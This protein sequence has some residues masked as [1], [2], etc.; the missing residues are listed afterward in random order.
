VW[1]VLL[2]TLGFGLIGFVDDLLIITRGKNLGLRA[3][4]KLLGQFIVAIAF[5][6]WYYRADPT[7][8]AWDAPLF[9]APRLLLSVWYVFLMV[10]LSNA[11]NLT[12]GLDGLAAGV[13]LPSWVALGVIGAFS[14]V[15][16]GL[17]AATDYGLVV[18]CAAFA[19]AT[20]GYLWYN[21]HPAQV[22]MGD[23]GSL[24]IGGGLTA[25][26]IALHQ[27]WVLLV[28]TGIPLIEMFSVILQVLSFKLTKKRIFK[29]SPLHHHFELCELP[30]TRIVA[31]FGIASALFALT[32][33][34]IV[35]YR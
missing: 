35:F 9:T 34:L 30:E 26:A 16:T 32:A 5:A 25:A 33:L 24:A 21:A 31:R 19:G 28:I 15:V 23:T 2:A 29:M 13:T 10:G 14:P 17:G 7:R 1:G 8:A 22:F 4:E 6:V 12:D 20:I 3:R 18:F 11:V 27:E